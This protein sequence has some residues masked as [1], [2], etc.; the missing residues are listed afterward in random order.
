MIQDRETQKPTGLKPHQRSEIMA[1]LDD[2]AVAQLLEPGLVDMMVSFALLELAWLDHIIKSGNYDAFKRIPEYVVLDAVSWLNFVLYWGKPAFLASK[3]I[4]LL[5]SA[6]IAM[7]DSPECVRSTLVHN[8]IIE[9]LLAMLSPQLRANKSGD[10]GLGRRAMQTGE[11]ALVSAVLST[12]AC[13]NELVPALM[14]CYVAADHVVGLD[15]DKDSFDKFQMRNSI[16][17]ILAELWKDTRCHGKIVQL[18]SSTS[19]LTSTTPKHHNTDVFEDYIGCV[20][21]GL[22]YLFKDSLDRLHDIHEIEKSMADKPAWDAMLDADREP[23]EQFYK[24]QQRTCS[25]FMH[26]AT[27]NLSWLMTLTDDPAVA[28]AF[29]KPPVAGRLAYAVIHFLDLLLGP[30]C[31]SLKVEKPEKYHFD[32]PTLMEGIIGLLLR[33]AQSPSFIQVVASEPDLDMQSSSFIHVVASEPDLKMQSSSF[34]HVVA[35]EP[36]LEMQSSFIHV[37]A[38]EP[39]LEMQSSSFIH[40]VASE[41]D[42]EMQSSSFIHVVALEPDLEM[43][44]SSFIHVVASEPDLEMQSSSFIHVVASEPDLEMQIFA[45]ALETLESNHQHQIAVGLRPFLDAVRALADEGG[46]DPPSKR[47]KSGAEGI[48]SGVDEVMEE[49]DGLR[50]DALPDL[51]GTDETESKYSGELEELTVAPFDSSVGGAYNRHF[52]DSLIRLNETPLPR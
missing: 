17:S 41:P 2:C 18:A 22:I 28:P 16:D 13:Q 30:R 49:E 8:K 43:Q 51:P 38:S 29:S 45:K 23:K 14:S 6:L 27:N 40:V 32:I 25:S 31:A 33:V 24:S 46:A 48:G 12:P 52:T 20:L 4:G 15:V 9:L 50:C 19:T 21:N 47:R 36:D 10:T 11:A 3:P 7:L 39:D 42:L 1:L 5:M 34:I 44:S 35:S 26:S 37:V